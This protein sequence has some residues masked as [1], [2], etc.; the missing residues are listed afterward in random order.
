[1]TPTSAAA[2]IAPPP[3][4]PTYEERQQPHEFI[5]APRMPVFEVQGILDGLPNGEA[6]LRE[7]NLRVRADDPLVSVR[8]MRRFDMRNGD[9]VVMEARPGR[10]RGPV[11][12]ERVVSINDEPYDEHKKRPRFEDLTPC[13]PIG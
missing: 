5:P 10:G 7:E 9:S 2:P 8:D 6:F 1:M 4:P 13:I 3:P 11:L 12:V